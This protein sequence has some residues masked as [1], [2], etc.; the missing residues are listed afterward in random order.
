MN[1][2]AHLATYSEKDCKLQ[3]VIHGPYDM[4]PYDMAHIDDSEHVIISHQ[5]KRKCDIIGKWFRNLWVGSLDLNVIGI[6]T[7]LTFDVL[8]TFQR[9]P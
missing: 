8:I 2:H 1:E 7:W 9:K 5:N 4:G 3:S 6:V